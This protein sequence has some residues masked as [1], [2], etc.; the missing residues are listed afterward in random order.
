[1]N[2]KSTNIRS[3]A[4]AHVTDIISAISKLDRAGKMAVFVIK[5]QDLRLTPR[6]RPEELN[7]ISLVDRLADIEHKMLKMQQTIGEHSPGLLI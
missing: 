3:E 6:S 5:V 4:E 7:N 2:R 1:M